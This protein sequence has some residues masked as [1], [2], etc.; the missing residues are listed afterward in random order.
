M[1]LQNFTSIATPENK[2]KQKEKE[3]Q[4]EENATRLKLKKN[5]AMRCVILLCLCRT[6]NQQSVLCKTFSTALCSFTFTNL[7]YHIGIWH[8]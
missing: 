1:D 7:M 6:D 2:T 5:K 3:K 8:R 4:L